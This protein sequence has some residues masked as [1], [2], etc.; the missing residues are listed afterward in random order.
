M[1]TH[2]LC[3]LIVLNNAALEYSFETKL[4]YYTNEP[5]EK[6]LKFII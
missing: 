5:C 6:C 3:L 4:V 2:A 1:E